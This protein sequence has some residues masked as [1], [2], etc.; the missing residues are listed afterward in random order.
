MTDKNGSACLGTGRG[1]FGVSF[2]KTAMCHHQPFGKKRSVRH[3][4]SGCL[5]LDKKKPDIGCKN[6][7]K[8]CEGNETEPV[9]EILAASLKSARY[10]R[11]VL[12]FK[13]IRPGGNGVH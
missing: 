9:D 2:S 6:F 10:T 7:I 3:L 4:K 8:R 12:H 13:G 5:V 1:A 11:T